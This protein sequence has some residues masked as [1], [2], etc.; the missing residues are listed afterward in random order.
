MPPHIWTD[1]S[2]ARRSWDN[3]HTNV[4]RHCASNYHPSIGDRRRNQAIEVEYIEPPA[5]YELRH[6]VKTA[7][8]N[9]ANATAIKAATAINRI[10]T[11][12]I[13]D[14]N[15]GIIL[16]SKWMNIGMSVLVMVVMTIAFGYTLFAPM[17]IPN[18]ITAICSSGVGWA[19]ASTIVILLMYYTRTLER[20]F[21]HA[22]GLHK[23][24]P[25]VLS[26][27]NTILALCRTLL[28]L[29]GILVPG[30]AHLLMQ[31]FA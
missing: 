17:S 27:K 23:R 5:L 16:A 14:I 31:L 19:V 25:V 10:P 11:K 12:V 8:H 2:S 30:F 24:Q 7:V 13:H 21:M 29:Y 15:C 6:P 22:E 18:R 9:A 20:R 1:G 3:P 26:F 4:N 28:F